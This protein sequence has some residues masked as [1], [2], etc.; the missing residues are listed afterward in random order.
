MTNP[1]WRIDDFETESEIA[2]S[3]EY[4]RLQKIIEETNQYLCKPDITWEDIVVDEE[5]RQSIR[6]HIAYFKTVKRFERQRNLVL[7]GVSIKIV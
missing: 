3:E 2:Y 7:H 5:L 1:W 4:I 6:D